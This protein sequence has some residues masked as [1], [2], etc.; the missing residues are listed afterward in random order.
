MVEPRGIVSVLHLGVLATTLSYVFFA[1]GLRFVEPP[2]AVT[3]SLAEPLTAGLLGVIILGEN[4][5][6]L[7]FV[8]II[9]LFAGLAVLARRPGRLRPNAV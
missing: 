3:L 5:T 7:A 9:L 2:V 6:P 4:L 1:R 8:G